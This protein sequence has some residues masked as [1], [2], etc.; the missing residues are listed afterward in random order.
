MEICEYGK[1]NTRTILCLPGNFV[2]HRQFEDLVPALEKG[3]HVVMY[4]R[5]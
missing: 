1:E 2:T 4:G 3:V 5:K